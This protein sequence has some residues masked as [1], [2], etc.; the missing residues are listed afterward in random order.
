MFASPRYVIK[1]G[2]V[3]VE[4]G[5]IRQSVFGRTLFVAP[6]YDPD[7]ET[8]IRKYFEKYYT[9]EFENYP[10]QLEHYLPHPQE[11]ATE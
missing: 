11:I 1:D 6:G 9:I 10:V 8:D 3:L 7:I 4:D 5:H 2:Q